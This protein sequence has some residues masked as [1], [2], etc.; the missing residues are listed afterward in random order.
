LKLYSKLEI[1]QSDT[2]ELPCCTQNL[3]SNDE[4]IELIETSF[5]QA[6][7]I[8]EDE[9]SALY[10]I[11]GYVA[12]K[13][14]IG[15]DL[16]ENA[17]PLPTEGEYLELVSRGKLSHPPSDL[18][19][20]SMYYYSFFKSRKQKCCQKIFLE[21]YEEIYI[22]TDYYFEKIESINRRFSNC[23]FKA[24]VKKECSEIK[25]DS[26]KKNTMKRKLDN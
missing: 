15:V 26:Q 14:N 18:F 6:S 23:F 9:R 1:T 5:S 13:E 20:L 4:D 12:F 2:P 24:F 7:N 11:A 22:S 21:A 16:S 10:Y 19:D 25:N 17:T 3:Q 8:A